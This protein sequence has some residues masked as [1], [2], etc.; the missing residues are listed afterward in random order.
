MFKPSIPWRAGLRSRLW[1][2]RWAALTCYCWRLSEVAGSQ[3]WTDGSDLV[4][5]SRANVRITCLSVCSLISFSNAV[6]KQEKIPESACSRPGEDSTGPTREDTI[7]LKRKIALTK[8]PIKSPFVTLLSFILF[9]LL[10]SQ[11]RAQTLFFL[12]NAKKVLVSCEWIGSLCA[13]V[14]HEDLLFSV[15]DSNRG[16]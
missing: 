1:L 7:L 13:P 11:P 15:E 3:S 12:V 4:W 16:L 9:L 5:N 6:K 10:E 2:K 14:R 8:T